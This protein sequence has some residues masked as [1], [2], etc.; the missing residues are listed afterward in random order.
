VGFNA[1]FPRSGRGGC[2]GRGADRL[3][4][5]VIVEYAER[6]GGLGEFEYGDD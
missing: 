6:I 5:F 1:T 2:G 3:R 4:F